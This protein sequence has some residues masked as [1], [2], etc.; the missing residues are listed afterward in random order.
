MRCVPS[1]FELGN[2]NV[3]LG[4][5]NSAVLTCTSGGLALD[6]DAFGCFAVGGNANT[7]GNKVG[8]RSEPY[9]RDLRGGVAGVDNVDRKPAVAGRGGCGKDAGDA[10]VRQPFV[11]INPVGRRTSQSRSGSGLF[12]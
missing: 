6:E 7:L 12:E 10:Q 8:R 9:T 4:F 3:G 11:G 1:L 5:W 2:M